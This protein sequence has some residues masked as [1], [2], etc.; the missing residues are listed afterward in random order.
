[1]NS[2]TELRDQLADLLQG[3]LQ[4]EWVQRAYS[5][6]AV[7]A[8]VGDLRRLNQTNLAGKLSIAGFTL[9]AYV[10]AD[11]G[12]PQACETCMYYEI[13][14]QFCALPV[15]MLPVK[16]EWSCRLWRI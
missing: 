2:D 9:Q 16:P 14:R 7:N 13:H 15:L 1:M 3:G 11:E 12:I 6:E 10:D 8:I 4:T 5:S